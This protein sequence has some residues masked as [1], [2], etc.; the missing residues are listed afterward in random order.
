MNARIA[1]LKQAL[2]DDPRADWAYDELIQLLFESGKRADAEALARVALRVNPQNA[3]AHELFGTILSELND[4]PAGEW[5]FRRALE[6]GGERPTLLANLALNHMQQGRTD[7]AEREFARADALAPGAL[8]TLAHWS[9]LAEVRG[10]LPRAMALLDRA[11]AAHSHADVSLLRANHLARTGR[12]AEALA[13]I[14]AAGARNGDA[15]LERGRLL[16]RL[17]RHEEAWA[18]LVA[19]KRRLAAEA[20]GASY[21]TEAVETFM[22]RMKRFFVAPNIA[23][24][25]RAGT[26]PDVPQPLFIVGFPRSGTTLLEQVLASHSRVRAGGE[27]PFA[28]EL[29]ALSL[30]Q[31]PSPEGFPENL[32]QTWTADRR[33]AASLFRD[34]YLARAEHYG[35]TG[36][37]A[38]FFTDKMPFNEIW[39]PLLRMAFPEAKI[40][41]IVRHPLDVV[42]SMLAHNMTHGFNCGYAV[43]SIAHH[44]AAVADLDAHYAAQNRAG[45]CWPDEFTLRYEDFVADQRSITARLLD[46][47]GLP[48]EDACLDFHRNPR[49]APTPSYAQVT[50]KLNDRSIG[51]HRHYRAQLAPYLPLLKMGSDPIS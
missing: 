23:L 34:Y 48:F 44:L 32:S 36:P 25:P 17:G 40:V 3:R 42:V 4:L 37:G 50:Q 46:F 16:D 1:T 24:L 28:T 8:R 33:Y 5:H 20:G 51:R 7:D 6:L 18:Q 43:E 38:A 30:Q 14:D 29:R 22:A 15:M 39:L 47:L 12:T 31:F 19:G 49:Y 45:R 35:L 41:R 2:R 13:C 27:L 26:R 10:D 9:K 21:P 11:A